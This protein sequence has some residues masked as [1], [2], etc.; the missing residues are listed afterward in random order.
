M[1]NTMRIAL[2]S[3][4][5]TTNYSKTVN[6]TM[7]L[8]HTAVIKNIASAIENLGHEVECIEANNELKE[9]ILRI[10]PHI[11]FNRSNNEDGKTGLAFAPSLLDKLHIPYT[12]SDA[13]ACVTA[14]DKNKTKRI[15]QAVGIPTSKYCLISNANEIQIP[16]SLSFPLFIKP[17]QGGCSNGINEQNLVFSKESCINIT[18]TTIEQSGQ[19]VLV[20]EFLTGREYTVGILGNNPPQA[21]PILE[22][23]HDSPEGKNYMFRSFNS[24][25]VERSR[26]NKSCPAILS[27][28]E[29]NRIKNLAVKTYQ[30]LGCRDYARIDIRSNKNGIPHILEVNAFPSLIPYESSFTDIA[31]IAGIS[32]DNLINTILISAC[33]R[34]DIE[35]DHR[36]G[37]TNLFP[38]AIQLASDRKHSLRIQRAR[39][40]SLTDLTKCL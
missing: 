29:E 7:E 10:K 36:N 13:K 22:Y 30:L 33:E 3:D 9:N 24:K 26:E 5:I 4:S 35:F 18:K 11:V 20:E 14:F 31:E 17:I 2:I 1:N 21:L 34:Y 39:A 12:G 6:E 27:E 15:L 32:F 40:I 25:M 16:K 23:F 38:C 37:Q 19:P 28:I 8:T